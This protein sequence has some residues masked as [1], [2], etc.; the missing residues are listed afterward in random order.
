[1]RG[2]P[3]HL[4]LRA[5]REGLSLTQKQFAARLGIERPTYASY[6]TGQRPTPARV[7]HDAADAG[8]LPPGQ[9]AQLL[10]WAAS[11]TAAT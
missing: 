11:A 1:M 8:R 5:V 9:R 6:E 2:M 7:L 4:S 3:V 10:A